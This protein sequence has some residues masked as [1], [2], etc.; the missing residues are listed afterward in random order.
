MLF[1]S[2]YLLLATAFALIL[3][4]IIGDPPWLYRHVLHPV[5]ILG[6]LIGGLERYFFRTNGTADDMIRRGQLVVILLVFASFLVGIIIQWLCMQL[7]FGWVLL[8]IMMSPLL[9]QRSL[10][11]HVEAVG[12]GLDQGLDHGREA[13]SHIVGRDPNQLDEHGVARASIES[14]AENFSDGVVAPVFWGLLFGL[15]GM[16]AYKAI[17]TA[18]SMIGYKS[19]R[20][21][22][23]GKA[24]AKLD[25]VVNWVPARVSGLLISTA[26]RLMPGAR[27]GRSLQTMARD[28]GHHRSP[29]AGWP[30]AAMAG[31][32]DI[33]LSGPRSYNGIMTEDRW[34]GD[35]KIELASNDIER[36]VRLFWW[37]CGVLLVLILVFLMMLT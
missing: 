19:E 10:A 4:G 36:A 32:L 1:V 14:L 35:G 18:D 25:D 7:P 9:A 13:V 5:A 34:I 8:G 26:A 16:L 12:N 23:F 20:Y 17:N 24:V 21:L 6:S 15:P 30:E 31:A 3:D 33:R 37:S 2:E 28:A 22:Y 27:F 29:N 11:E